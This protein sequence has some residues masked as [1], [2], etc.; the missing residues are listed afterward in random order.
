VH[1]AIQLLGGGEVVMGWIVTVWPGVWAEFIAH[2]VWRQPDGSIL[3]ITPNKYDDDRILFL[4]D[5]SLGFDVLAL[6]MM[7]GTRM[8]LLSDH[9]D[10][11]TL[12]GLILGR[13]IQFWS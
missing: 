8:V 3:C 13:A 12:A 2:S 10:V 5:Q 4:P 7:I 9:P 6:P 11:R 1:N